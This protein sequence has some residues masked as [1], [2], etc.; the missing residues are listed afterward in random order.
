MLTLAGDLRRLQGCWRIRLGHCEP[1][2]PTTVN[3][4]A[5]QSENHYVPCLYLKRFGSS[6]GRVLTYR[7][8]VDHSRVPLWKET[9]VRGIAYHAHLYTRIVSGTQTD[10]VEKWLNAEFETPAEEALKRATGG[11]RLSPTDWHNLVRFL[12]AQDVRT[13]ARL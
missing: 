4:M 12:A 5:S 2:D 8:L 1:V 3:E 7:L 6:S 10:E 13:P 9:S 11:S